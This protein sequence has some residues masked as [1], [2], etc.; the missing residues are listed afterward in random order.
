MSRRRITT[1]KTVSF[2]ILAFFAFVYLVPMVWVFLSA[3]K[4]DV[5]LNK[6]GGF[7]LLPKTWTLDNFYVILSSSNVKTPIYLWFM[8]SVFVSTVFSGLS[9]LITSM[10]AFA[11]SKLR[12]KGRDTLFLV[13][14]F[15]SSFPA[16]MNIVPLYK[17]MQILGWINTPWALI[18]PGLVGTFNIFLMKQFMIGIP[19]SILEACK[20]EGAGDILVFF[21][22]VIPLSAPILLVVG[23]FSFTWIWND[24]LWP[25]IIINDVNR[26]TL[27]AGLKLARGTY[28][29]YVSKISA[30]S[31]VSIAPMIL[32]YGIAEKWLIRG[33]SISAG[34]KG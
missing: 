23:I 34:V 27:T 19:D 8:N 26:L 22:M 1:E 20:I 12:F 28:E 18:V 3:F 13:V 32:L 15:A 31:V 14:L 24:F 4:S 33:V 10:S 2:L 21:R 11:Y 9:I 29:T 16:I 5:E 30:I 7:L 25:S 17:I 6:A